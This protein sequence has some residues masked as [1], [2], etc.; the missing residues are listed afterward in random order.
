MAGPTGI[1]GVERVDLRVDDLPAALDFYERVVGLEALD[2]AAVA[3]VRRRGLRVPGGPRA[4]AAPGVTRRARAARFQRVTL[5]GQPPRR[6]RRAVRPRSRDQAATFSRRVATA[7]VGER[8]LPAT[9]AGRANERSSR[10]TTARAAPRDGDARRQPATRCRHRRGE[11]DVATTCSPSALASS[12]AGG[13][14]RRAARRRARRATA[15][16]VHPHPT[17]AASTDCLRRR[18]AASSVHRAP[19]DGDQASFLAID[20]YHHH[21]GLNTWYSLGAGPPD[22]SAAGLDRVVVRR[23]GRR[24]RPSATPTVIELV[25]RPRRRR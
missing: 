11:L 18:R 1:T 13:A 24:A 6:P 16:H 3:G 2:G 8:A 19:L 9:G 20:G 25:L 4:R 22:G 12:G 23:R 7:A 17:S 15:G 14:R 5:P 10:R 21:V